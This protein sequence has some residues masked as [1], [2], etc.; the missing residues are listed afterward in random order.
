MKGLWAL[1][2]NNTKKNNHYYYYFIR[3]ASVDSAVKRVSGGDNLVTDVQCY[4]LFG[5]IALKNHAFSF[6][7]CFDYGF[8]DARIW[9]FLVW[10]GRWQIIS[11]LSCF[12]LSAMKHWSRCRYVSD[13]VISQ[14]RQPNTSSSDL[15]L[16]FT[17]INLIYAKVAL[18]LTVYQLRKVGLITLLLFL[19]F[20][21]Q[22]RGIRHLVNRAINHVNRLHHVWE[23][24]VFQR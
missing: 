4:E 1:R 15:T 21:R 23:V 14:T 13:I 8:H 5:G 7:C 22:P 16:N 17:Q 20:Q 6:H 2:R 10:L 11:W 18:R 9:E 3:I 19:S 12:M 24:C